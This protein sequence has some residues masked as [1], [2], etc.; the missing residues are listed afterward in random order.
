MSQFSGDQP[1]LSSYIKEKG[2]YAAGRLD[3]NSE[4]LLLLTNDGKLQSRIT[5]PSFKMSKHYLVQLEGQ[6]TD[7]A[8][9]TLRSGITLRDGKTLPAATEPID[10][11]TLHDRSPTIRLRKY[12][13]TSWIEISIR[14]GRN[15]QIRRMTAAVGFPTL[16]LFR[17]GVGP[18]KVDGIKSGEYRIEQ[19]NLP[20]H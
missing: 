6:I 14:E 1:N 15:R 4:G 7:A 9:A 10:T 13:K 16:R 12:L 2:Y 11:P 5:D 18:W 3:K 20:I 17:L 19:V 8:L